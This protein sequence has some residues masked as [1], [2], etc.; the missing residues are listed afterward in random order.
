[1]TGS[2]YKIHSV[3]LCILGILVVLTSVSQAQEPM[4]KVTSP[5]NGE[6]VTS[7]VSVSGTI[8][9]DIPDNRY[10]WVLVN[11]ELTPAQYWPQGGDHVIPA[12]RLWSW[13]ANLG[14]K[15]GEKISILAVLVD[16]DTNDGYIQWDI[17]CKKANQWTPVRLLD[18]ATIMDKVTVVLR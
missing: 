16:K 10:L 13:V 2:S 4:I 15:S 7:P 5:L 3:L 8:I 14:G 11:P 9:G 6:V 17:D 18:N 12:N 1:M